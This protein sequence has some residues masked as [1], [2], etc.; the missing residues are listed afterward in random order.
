MR[1]LLF[2]SLFLF[3]FSSFSEGG[4]ANVEDTNDLPGFTQKSEVLDIFSVDFSDFISLDART[5]NISSSSQ[6][7]KNDRIFGF[8]ELP[9]LVFFTCKIEK[10]YSETCIDKFLKLLFQFTIQVNAP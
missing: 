1:R 5:R 2:A 9:G 10:S 7:F 4:K 8:I 6:R 3:G